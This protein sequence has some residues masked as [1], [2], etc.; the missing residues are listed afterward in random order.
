MGFGAEPPQGLSGVVRAAGV[1]GAAEDAR[2]GLHGHAG[3]S[4]GWL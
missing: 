1:G 3:W 4:G 2:E